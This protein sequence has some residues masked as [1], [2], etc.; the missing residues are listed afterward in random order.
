[1]ASRGEV[2]EYSRT[3]KKDA[4]GEKTPLQMECCNSADPDT[5]TAYGARCASGNSSC[6]A[7][8]CPEGTKEC[9]ARN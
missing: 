5:P 7:N 8:P 3:W 2:Q 4:P 1:V 9:G 6:V